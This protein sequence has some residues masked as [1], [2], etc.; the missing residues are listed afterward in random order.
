MD[1]THK[2]QKLSAEQ[3]IMLDDEQ[4]D[5]DIHTID[6][7]AYVENPENLTE[8]PIQR[9]RVQQYARQGRVKEERHYFLAARYESWD[10]FAQ[11]YPKIVTGDQGFP[12]YIQF[13]KERLSRNGFMRSFELDQD[14][15]KQDKLTT[16]IEFLSWEYMHYNYYTQQAMRG[17]YRHGKA[18]KKLQDSGVLEPGETEAIIVTLEYRLQL[19]D[20]EEKAERAVKR[21]KS[22][23]TKTKNNVERVERL[24]GSRYGPEAY[25]RV[26]QNLKEA[27]ED[28]QLAEE[29]FG[30]LRHRNGCINRFVKA[31]ESYRR[32]SDKTENHWKLI[33]WMLQQV[34]LIE[35]ELGLSDTSSHPK[36]ATNDAEAAVEDSSEALCRDAPAHTTCN[37][38]IRLVQIQGST[39]ASGVLSL[40]ITQ[41]SKTKRPPYTAVSYTWGTS[42]QLLSIRINGRPFQI[43]QNLWHL[44]FH[45]RQRGESR[46]LWIDA[47]CID[48]SHLPERN[49]HVQLMSKIYEDAEFA[50]V[51]LGP[52]S[53]DRREARAMDFVQEMATHPRQ[54]A[55]KSGASFRDVYL[56]EFLQAK[57][58]EV[59]CGIARLEWIYFDKVYL[60]VRELE[61]VPDYLAP[62][63]K[64]FLTTVPCR[65]TA[66]RLIHRTSRLEDLLHE[67]YDAQ[68]AEP[69]DKVYGLLGIA[70]DCADHTEDGQLKGPQPDYGQHIVQVYFDVVRYLSELSPSRAVA[71]CTTLLLQQA[72][73]LDVPTLMEF[74]QQ[75]PSAFEFLLCPDY[76]SAV[77]GVVRGWTS[78][79]DLKNQLDRLDWATYVGWEVLR[80]TRG[81]KS[82][83][84]QLTRTGSP[85]PV[86]AALPS[87]L[88]S[89]AIAFAE[90]SPVL[91]LLFNY[92]PVVNFRLPLDYLSL[93]IEDKKALSNPTLQKPTLIIEASPSAEPVRL[94]FAC[95]NVRKGDYV[96]QFKGL[97]IA[98]IGRKLGYAG[99]MQIVG[100]A[101]M[102]RH[103]GLEGKHDAVHPAG[104]LGNDPL[105]S[106]CLRPQGDGDSSTLNEDT[107]PPLVTDP[108][109]VL[110]SALDVFSSAAIAAESPREEP[111]E[112]AD[113][114]GDG[115]DAN[116]PRDH[117]VATVR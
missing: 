5:K 102:I 89:N 24:L 2:D 38:S 33:R 61:T 60:D 86:T 92:P 45:L 27:E 54:Q 105:I 10:K 23:V 6:R 93:H 91:S 19:S 29:A 114:E 50:I 48:Q 77:S 47:L 108:N 16:W 11:V 18:W 101:V 110:I 69:R 64:D 26:M 41:F 20:E 99:G 53:D 35:Q 4:L 87:D 34:P 63:L 13:V 42:S 90:T 103:Q 88:I 82:P 117:I 81:S 3:I 85:R 21:A 17:Q 109:V 12:E 84:I 67:F 94:G 76:V 97:D 51:W 112:E 95:T 100:K 79:R 14:I 59:L 78:L 65:L 116:D 68:C 75:L 80:S 56:S 49:F 113:D 36:G 22:D 7:T 15:A 70:Q 46:F 73:A 25:Q 72:L 40:R 71:P 107:G 1:S 104:S 66:R 57:R 44:L 39:S 9:L 28:L 74:A 37:Q 31:T 106:P 32:F 8:E 43:H 52:P 83:S 96:L 98:L 111:D 62:E 58:I 55:G 115:Q 30:R